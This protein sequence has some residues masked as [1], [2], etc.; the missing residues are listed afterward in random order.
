MLVALIRINARTYFP[1][2]SVKYRTWYIPEIPKFVSIFWKFPDFYSAWQKPYT[3]DRGKY[4]QVQ[5]KRSMIKSGPYMYQVYPKVNGHK[6]GILTV[7]FAYI[8]MVYLTKNWKLWPSTFYP[9]LAV[10]AVAWTS[11]NGAKIQFKPGQTAYNSSSKT[12]GQIGG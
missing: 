10:Q 8:V 4:E 9:L 3:Y 5:S 11:V 7:F 2:I 12:V 1:Y 6:I